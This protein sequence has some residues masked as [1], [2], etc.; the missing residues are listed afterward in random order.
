M[1]NGHPAFPGALRAAIDKRGISL[2]RLG[3]RLR[4]MGTPV[5]TAT[6]SYWQTG[7]TQPRPTSLAAL[8]NVEQIVG[9]P[10]GTLAALLD[11]PKPRGRAARTRQIVL[12]TEFFPN[13]APVERLLD[14]LDIS[15]D[16]RLTRLSG[17]DRIDIGADRGVRSRTS[18]QVLRAEDDDLD[19]LVVVHELDLPCAI[20]PQVR[21]IRNCGLGR[22]RVDVEAGLV[23][24]E[25]LF[26]RPL[27][28]NETILIE[29]G[30][31]VSS[32]ARSTYYERRCRTPVREYLVE[33]RFD[34]LALP[35]RVI[36]YCTLD[37]VEKYWPAPLDDDHSA[38]SVV[39]DFGP[40]RCGL[41]WDWPLS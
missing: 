16:A 1:R 4:A 34:P 27:A 38:H 40:G 6:L 3:A 41:R 28:R 32:P 2:E 26:S 13:V 17:H 31:D 14:G 29:H 12:G 23:A 39:V 35:D 8:R 36:R 19:R 10:Q 7:R 21:A 24:A 25:L 5:S 30:L 37:E 11:P 20:P 18:R 22:V 15:Q 9:L 33:V